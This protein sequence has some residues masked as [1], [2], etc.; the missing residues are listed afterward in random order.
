MVPEEFEALPPDAHKLQEQK[1]A[2]QALTRSPECPPGGGAPPPG[3]L[4]Q[5]PTFWSRSQ[6]QG[7]RSHNTGTV[8]KLKPYPCFE[9]VDKEKMLLRS[10]PTYKSQENSLLHPLMQVKENSLD[11]LNVLSTVLNIQ[12]VIEKTSSFTFLSS[13]LVNGFSSMMTTKNLKSSSWPFQA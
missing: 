7:D 5:G 1:P 13:A 2:F 9:I 10:N 12:V 3:F 4:S 11:S 8:C 6:L